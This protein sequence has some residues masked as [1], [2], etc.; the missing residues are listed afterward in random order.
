MNQGTAKALSKV[1]SGI[2]VVFAAGLLKLTIGSMT[3]PQE[4]R[5]K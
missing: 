1:V 2:S 4:L 5:K 3:T